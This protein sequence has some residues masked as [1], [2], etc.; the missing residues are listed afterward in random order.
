M[1]NLAIVAIVALF[2]A[3]CAQNKPNPTNETQASCPHH[4]MH[5]ADMKSCDKGCDQKCSHGHHHGH[6]HHH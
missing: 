4:H 3:G 5:H 6:H 2:F 1:K